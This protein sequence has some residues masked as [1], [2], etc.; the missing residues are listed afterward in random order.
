VEWSR[1]ISASVHRLL[2][3]EGFKACHALIEH[4]AALRRIAGDGMVDLS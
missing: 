1:E 3:G 4:I 2:V